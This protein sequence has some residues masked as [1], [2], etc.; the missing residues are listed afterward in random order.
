LRRLAIAALLLAPA[1]CDG[2]EPARVTVPDSDDSAPSTTIE[3]RDADGHARARASQPPEGDH[4]A[5]T[6]LHV[7]RLRAVAE[8]RDTD[9][10]VARVR[11]SIR[12]EILCR[13]PGGREALRPR[14]RY[15]PP[16]QIERIR[17]NP[18]ARLPTTVTR[19]LALALVGERCGRAEPVSVRGELWG[20]T[21]NGSGLESV[22][23]HL[24]FR[25][26]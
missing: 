9:G 11:I 17:S 26:P 14:T 7:P 13:H 25:W 5:P 15:F 8:G 12:E 4:P 3:L 10:G 20:E 21:T 22:T 18:G 23:P 6:T 1:G 2:D 19:T 24:R 16:S